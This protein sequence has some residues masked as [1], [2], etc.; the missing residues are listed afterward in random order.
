M[1]RYYHKFSYCDIFRS[2]HNKIGMLL[3]QH[4]QLYCCLPVCGDLRQDTT[5]LS[6]ELKVDPAADAAQSREQQ[7][8]Q[9]KAKQG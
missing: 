7:A 5:V 1:I 9:E 4:H 8:E 3:K 6:T 2:I